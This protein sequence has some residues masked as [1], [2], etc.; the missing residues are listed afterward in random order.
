VAST[1]A[2]ALTE[3]R[4]EFDELHDR[5]RPVLN[6]VEVL[7]GVVPNCDP[8]LEIWP[9]GFRTYNL[10]VPNF[11]NLPAAL[12]GVGAPKDIVGLAMYTSS[13]AASCAYCSAHT[14]SFA[15]RRGSSPDA[16]TD[17]ERTDR[18]A[19]AV[20]VAEALST[21]PH[22]Y[23][24]DLGEELRRHFSPG[25]A[26]WVVMGAAMM[27]FLNK[28]MDAIGVELEPEA[29]GD[30]ADL[31]EPT[32]W[33]VGQHGWADDDL[34]SAGSTQASPPPTDSIGSLLRVLRNAPGAV[35]LDRRW[36]DRV[37]KDAGKARRL[38]AG[39]Y[40]YDEPILSE[41][42]HAK[43]RRA[44]TAMLRHNLDPDQ[45][46]VGIG[47]KA[48]AGLVLANHA[49]NKPLAER[50]RALAAHHLIDDEV[51]T[52]ADQV[53]ADPGAL[54]A[55]DAVDAADETTKAT[56]RLAQAV[57]PSP[58]AVDQATIEQ[59]SASLTSAQIVE[60]VVWVSVSQLLHRLSLYYELAG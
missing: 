49:G 41:M 17:V 37:P 34:Q 39:T 30:V 28:F 60:A 7:I 1:L 13:R 18:E 2:E 19:A 45:S 12:L 21:V 51:I 57:A 47:V 3:D 5:Y 42:A 27:G 8:Y 40:A 10:M 29:V 53:H 11:L 54:G 14:C 20:A 48:L 36:T 32:G 38:I 58:A 6:M 43:P 50:A 24:A 44:L 56:L 23:T 35:R 9:P 22:H 59:V 46:A 25:D 15:L 16:V 4:I 55:L 33:S 52:T 26:E 31:I